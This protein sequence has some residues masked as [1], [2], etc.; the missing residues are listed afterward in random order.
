MAMGGG[1]EKSGDR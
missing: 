1:G